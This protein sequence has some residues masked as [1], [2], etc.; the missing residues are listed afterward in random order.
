[1]KMILKVITAPFALILILLTALCWLLFDFC[2]SFL[3]I[4]SIFMAILG[5]DL[6][7]TGTT[8]G[9]VFLFLTLLLSLYGLQ[10]MARWLIGVLDGRK[11]ALCRFLVN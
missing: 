3:T 6:F 8:G 4:A 7:H 1:M 5:I 9:F 10:V 2:A 11:S